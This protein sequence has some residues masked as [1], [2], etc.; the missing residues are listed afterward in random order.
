MSWSHIQMVSEGQCD[1]ITF[2]CKG[3]VAQEQRGILG[4]YFLHLDWLME[5]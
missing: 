2:T 5:A 1:I 4:P 3:T